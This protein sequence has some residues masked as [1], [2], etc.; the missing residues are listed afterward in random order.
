MRHGSRL[1]EHGGAQL[2]QVQAD[3]L[4]D[5]GVAL[6]SRDDAQRAQQRRSGFTRMA[7]TERGMQPGVDEVAEDQIHDGP[8]AVGFLRCRFVAH[9]PIREPAADLCSLNLRQRPVA[10]FAYSEQHDTTAV[11]A[12]NAVAGTGQEVRVDADPER[13]RRR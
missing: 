13:R 3:F 8:G 1:V 4:T 9:R 6:V 12:Y 11:P 7:A 10:P 5:P 2:G